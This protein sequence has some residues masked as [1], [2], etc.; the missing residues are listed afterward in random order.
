MRQELPRSPFTPTTTDC[1]NNPVCTV[2]PP[3]GKQLAYQATGT[4]K[5]R[6]RSWPVSTDPKLF[7][8][9]CPAWARSLPWQ[10][11]LRPPSPPWTSAPSATASPSCSLLRLHPGALLPVISKKPSRAWP[12]GSAGLG[13]A[14]G[15]PKGQ[16]RP[17]SFRLLSYQQLFFFSF[18]KSLLSYL[19]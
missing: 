8:E 14:R 9:L 12:T 19:Y 7:R 13:G 6:L 2:F 15:Q 11:H 17:R 4:A 16:V 10:S 18:F 5:P 3:L 1:E